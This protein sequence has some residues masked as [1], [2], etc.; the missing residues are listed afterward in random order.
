MSRKNWLL[1]VVLLLAAG[2]VYFYSVVWQAKKNVGQTTVNFLATLDVAKIDQMAIKS[3][4]REVT[5]LKDGQR[6]RVQGAGNFY[7]DQLLVEA[8]LNSLSQASRSRVFLVSRQSAAKAALRTDGSNLT[9]RLIGGQETLAEFNV[10]NP[11]SS[12][13]YLAPL[14]ADESYEFSGDLGRVFD[15]SDWRDYTIL[16]YNRADIGKLSWR[17]GQTEFSVEK[18][19]DDWLASTDQKNK[20]NPEKFEPLL[21]LVSNLRA[22][23]LPEQN[24]VLSG[25]AKPFLTIEISGTVQRTLLVGAP[26][27]DR[28]GLPT[29]RY[30]AKTAVAD[31]IYLISE[32]QFKTLNVSLADL[33]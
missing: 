26:E 19:K 20:L 4:D 21:A 22:A 14:N 23:G 17:R 13:V 33:R 18:I 32:E 15:P 12:S 7:A 10:G 31:T 6:W 11:S 25:L 24:L 29:G 9:V 30:Y 8:A 1:A 3:K 16:N 27:R 28:D 5:L 2:G